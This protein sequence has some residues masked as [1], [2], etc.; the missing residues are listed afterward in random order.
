MRNK[1]TYWI[2][3][4]LGMEY[5]PE[6]VY[7]DVVMNGEYYG[8]YL[9]SE[10][11]RLASQ[12]VD[13]D[14]L[15]DTP[16]AVDEPTITGG[17]LLSMS[18]DEEE[19]GKKAFSTSRENSFLIESPTFEEQENEAQYNYIKNYVQKTEDAIYDTQ[20]QNEGTSYREYMDVT[21]AAKYYWIQEFS[22]NGDGFISNLSLIHI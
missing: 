10:Q 5:T 3:Q 16:D 15:E 4:Q 11:V 20:F 8:S 1:A 13:L 17:Y 2:G 19:P 9:L 12:R 21:S 7:V 14:N 6:C 18:P 22:A